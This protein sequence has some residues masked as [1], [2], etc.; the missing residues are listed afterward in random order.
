M[1]EIDKKLI[2]YKVNPFCNYGFDWAL[3]SAGKSD[4]Y[5]T[6]TVSWGEMGTL[7]S[8]PICTVFIKPCRYTYKYMEEND[9]FTISFFDEKYKNDLGFIGSHSGRDLD[10]IKN[11]SLNIIDIDNGIMF[12]EAKTTILCKKIY[13]DDF[14]YDRLS[15]DIIDHYYKEELPH[16]I[17]VGEVIK[18]ID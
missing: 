2:D 14:K 9:Y 1:Y 12:K 10:K 18:I 16:R 3:V 17:Y 5:N 13:S 7:W 4:N 8:K 11:T 6:M 15:K